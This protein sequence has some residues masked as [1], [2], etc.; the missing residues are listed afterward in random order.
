V[1][2]SNDYAKDF[3]INDPPSFYVTLLIF[4]IRSFLAHFLRPLSYFIFLFSILSLSF[5]FILISL[6]LLSFLI[7]YIFLSRFLPSI[8]SIIICHLLVL[9]SFPYLPFL[10]SLLSLYLAFFLSF[11]LGRASILNSVQSAESQKLAPLQVETCYYAAKQLN[12]AL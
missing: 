11:F 9:S 4:L 1:T 5:L 8:F 12:D 3:S 10:I 7:F 2:I 6:I